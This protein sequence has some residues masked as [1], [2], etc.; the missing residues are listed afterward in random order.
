MKFIVK[1][2]PIYCEHFCKNAYEIINVIVNGKRMNQ[3]EFNEKYPVKRSLK[4]QNYALF[5]LIS[6]KKV[7]ENINDN[8]KFFMIVIEKQ[9]YTDYFDRTSIFSFA[10]EFDDSPN[11][12]AHRTYLGDGVKWD[13]YGYES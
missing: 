10:S 1:N 11:D 8:T 12:E 7:L 13:E 9:P 3:T 6:S 4:A 5:L 2:N